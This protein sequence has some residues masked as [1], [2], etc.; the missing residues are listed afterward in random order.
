MNV[1]IAVSV[2]RQD[3][4]DASVY[5]YLQ[6]RFPALE[7]CSEDT[8]LIEGGA[9]DSLGFLELMMFLSEH[10]G[11]ELS[12]ADFDPSVLGTPGQLIAFV[13]QARR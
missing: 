6:W 11:I 7:G 9:L 3:D 8:P 2:T 5:S 4:V 12:D 13:R 1:S 10:F